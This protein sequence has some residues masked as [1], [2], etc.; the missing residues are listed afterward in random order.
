MSIQVELGPAML[1]QFESDLLAA[2]QKTGS[3]GMVLDMS[4]VSV[5]DKHDFAHLVRILET[6]KMMG[7]FPVIS[8][9]QAG[10]VSYLIDADVEWGEL[11]T[12]LHL[13][14]G[15]ELLDRLLADSVQAIGRGVSLEA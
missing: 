6:V 15:I 5:L 10:V 2:L 13:D 11:H 7:V 3:R 8:G 4:G 9:L 1:E 12:C 14:R